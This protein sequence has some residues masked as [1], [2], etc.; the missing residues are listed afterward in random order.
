[1]TSKS[2]V[3]TS[4]VVAMIA[5]LAKIIGFGR[6]AVIAA[7]YG[8]N[9]STDAY[10]LAQNMPGMIFP[11]LC[12]S[13]VAAFLPIYVSKCVQEGEEKGNRFASNVLMVTT[14]LAILLSIFAY[15]ITP[16]IVPIF[17]S[18]FS[19][20]TLILAV[21]LTR[22]TMASFVLIMVYSILGTVLN[23]K[24]LFYRAQ[25]AGII[26]NI[27]V[28]LVTLMFGK[29]QSVEFLTW[30][31]VVGHLVQVIA[32]IL[33][34][35]GKVKFSLSLTPIDE[36]IKQLIRLTTP[37]LLGNSVIQ[38]NTIIGKMLASN[39]AEGAI[40]A[41]SYSGTLN[42][43]V[44]GVF[45][46][47]LSTVLYPTLT[48]NAAGDNDFEFNNNL[49]K[50]LNFLIMALVPVSIITILFSTDIVTIVFERGSFNKIAT[51]MTAETLMYYA[52]GYTF[53]AIR[54]VLVRAFYAFG[55]S[56]TPMFNGIISVGTNI[57]F[58]IV[59]SRFMGIAG[60]A[61]GT[62]I[63]SMLTA[64]LLII[65]IKKHIKFIKLSQ[66]LPTTIK[67]FFAGCATTIVLL[68]V[69]RTFQT[70]SSLSRFI[71]AA[72]IGFSVYFIILL[73]ENCEEVFVIKNIFKNKFKR[74]N[75]G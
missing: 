48:E 17:A 24:K 47:S 60:I 45:I 10:F 65:S 73:F 22:I 66:M 62:S 68:I 61:L 40:S 69:S 9:A 19:D 12:D 42:A 31:V 56:R 52:V 13:I 6:E 16:Y 55:N 53:A 49:I 43:V 39:V 3:R 36:D 37:I 30:T 63:A 1:M 28:I 64:I 71:L 44:T 38:I 34:C 46:A 41:L 54:E 18:G 26:F 35:I 72:L 50:S 67:L 59:L 14:V 5:I 75:K 23:A 21:K 74:S 15:F 57:I 29:E 70:L 2:I 51:I 4:I 27:I 32:L 33:F 58:S 25:I 7:F 8:A 20:E 11:A